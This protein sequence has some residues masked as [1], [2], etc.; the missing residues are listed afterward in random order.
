VDDIAAALETLARD[1]AQLAVRTDDPA[2]SRRLDEMTG[3]VFAL[4]ERVA[5]DSRIYHSAT[6]LRHMIGTH[7]TDDPGADDRSPRPAQRL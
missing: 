4:A 5:A 6:S 7:M 3:E 2:I 1:L